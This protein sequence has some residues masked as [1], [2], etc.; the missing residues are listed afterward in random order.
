MDRPEP[1][2][3][4]NW[5]QAH[6][7]NR[8][9]LLFG[10]RFVSLLTVRGRRTG[11]PHQVPVAVLDLDGDRYLLA[12]RGSTHWVRNLRAAGAGELRRGGSAHSFRAVEVPVEERAPLIAAYRRRFDRFPSVAATFEQLPDPADHPTFRLQ[13]SEP[14]ET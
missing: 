13:E 8:M 2:L 12:P 4:P 3:P 5:M 1:Y 6:V 7:G 11:K 10:R 14:A 9:A